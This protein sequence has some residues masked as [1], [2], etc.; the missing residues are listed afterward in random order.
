[1]DEREQLAQDERTMRDAI[2]TADTETIA[3]QAKALDAEIMRIDIPAPVDA[4][5]VERSLEDIAPGYIRAFVHQELKEVSKSKRTVTHLITNATTDRAGDVVVPLGA[6]VANYLRNPLVLVDHRYEVGKIAGRSLALEISKAGILSTTQFRDTPLGHD[7]LALSAEGLGGWSIGFHPEEYDAL[8]DEKGQRRGFEFKVWD[9]LEY[10]LVA[11]PMNPDIVNNA[12]QR[13][14]VT[15]EHA[16]LFFRS[17]TPTPPTQVEAAPGPIAAAVEM[18]P[19][20]AQ[21]ILRASKR[22]DRMFA[23]AAVERALRS[24]LEKCNGR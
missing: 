1:M 24:E 19:V 6:K 3:E 9:L 16:P 15:P 5:G 21:T 20:L 14:W 4:D 11:I 22:N 23:Y 12:V 2:E 10:S 7:G 18:H 8:R 17:I 13:G